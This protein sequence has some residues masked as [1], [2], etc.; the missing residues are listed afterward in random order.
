MKVCIIYVKG[1]GKLTR[2]QRLCWHKEMHSWRFEE[3]SDPGKTEFF[4]GSAGM[5]RDNIVKGD[6]I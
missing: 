2:M 4:R 1:R 6:K 3:Q 5:V